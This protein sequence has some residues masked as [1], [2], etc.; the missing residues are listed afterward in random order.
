VSL[1]SYY[2]FLFFLSHLSYLKFVTI[3]INYF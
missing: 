2:F 3:H 1:K